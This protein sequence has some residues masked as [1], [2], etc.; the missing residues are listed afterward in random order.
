MLAA[1]RDERAT[2][3]SMPAEV[4]CREQHILSTSTDITRL[5]INVSRRCEQSGHAT[6]QS[7]PSEA[8]QGKTG[9]FHALPLYSK[10]RR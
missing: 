10:L 9:C 5:M 8:L 3:A 4:G 7:C 2:Q 1:Y 6:A